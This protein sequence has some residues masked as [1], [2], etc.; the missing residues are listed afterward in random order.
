MRTCRYVFSLLLIVLVIPLS[1]FAQA[2]KGLTFQATVKDPG[3]VLINDPGTAVN[4]KVLSPNDCI[5]LEESHAAVV[6][7]NGYLNIVVGKGVRGGADKGL[8]ANSIFNNLTALVSLDPLVGAPGTCNYTPVA[9]DARKMR[10]S[11]VSGGNTI[12]GDFNIRG[13][14]FAVDSELLGGKASSGYIQTSANT[15]QVKI[16]NILATNVYN[17]LLNLDSSN[18]SAF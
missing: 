17:N 6:I 1:S 13:S 10:I 11:F 12:T 15:T 5:L 18:T 16:D 9:Q 4:V 14:A 3:G 8:A 7:S 2:Y